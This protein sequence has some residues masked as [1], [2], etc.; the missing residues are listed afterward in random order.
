MRA[1]DKE[2]VAV[3]RWGRP[4]FEPGDWVMK[5]ETFYVPKDSIKWSKGK[6]MMEVGKAFLDKENMNQIMEGE[7]CCQVGFG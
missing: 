3:T 5:G 1:S 7:L 2:L 4:G 6:G